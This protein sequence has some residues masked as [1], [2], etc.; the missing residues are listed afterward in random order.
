[1]LTGPRAGLCLE[2]GE[3]STL[4]RSPSCE[5]C[6]ED[7]KI[8]RRHAVI[9]MERG[10]ARLT[11]LGSRNGTLVN[12]NRVDGEL[13]LQAGDQLQLGDSTMVYEAPMRLVLSDEPLAPSYTAE[14]TERIALGQQA[15]RLL[16][17]ARA[18]MGAGSESMVLRRA[19]EELLR[20][21]DAQRAAALLGG[22]RGLSTAVV[23]GGPSL[24]VPRALL[25]E[26]LERAA[27]IKAGGL[28]CVPM[29]LPSGR[30]FGVLFAQRS[31]PFFSEQK[32]MAAE[33]GALAAEAYCAIG[34][35]TGAQ[36]TRTAPIGEARPLKRAVEQARRAAASSEPVLI[37]GEEGTGKTLL[38]RFVHSRSGRSSSPFCVVDCR[39]SPAA[40]EELL[41][42]TTGLPGAPPVDS[43]IWRADA[44]TLCLRNVEALEP[45]VAIRLSE[46]LER[47]TAS[48]RSAQETS[49]DLRVI[50]TSSSA[51][52]LGSSLPAALA[53]QLSGIEIELAPLRERK[54]DIP[55]L[56]EA[57]FAEIGRALRKTPP[58][59]SAE[60]LRLLVEYTWPGNI[61]QLECLAA[62]WAHSFP[63]QEISARA[64]ALCLPEAAAK[65][66]ASL[67]EQV[68]QLERELV[69]EALRAS[70]GKKVAAAEMLGISRPTL[71]K[72][73]EEH[74]L[75]LERRRR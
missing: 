28:L 39:Q 47:R 25:H 30:P 65:P 13:F 12:G 26:V 40:V 31:E 51:G 52:P 42:G 53:R 21:V 38:A 49:V 33:I 4:G 24:E 58:T 70:R 6:L 8:S 63:G 23:V 69:S 74:Q 41:F 56:L 29:G 10:R 61:A 64:L 72:K 17:V 1:M 18:L 57:K 55:A 46:Q 45:A 43:A 71:D 2:L 32:Q 54:V 62:H 7:S 60:A 48:S 35:D 37:K 3:T 22:P 27:G 50:A 68:A 16:E 15:G 59:L 20:C 5:L 11:D 66:Q 9:S 44:G 36:A 34:R 14:E 67:H 75:K 73:I 19:A